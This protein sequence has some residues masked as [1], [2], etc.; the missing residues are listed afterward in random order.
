[1]DDIKNNEANEIAQENELKEQKEQ[2]LRVIADYENEIKRI[3]KDANHAMESAVESIVIEIAQ[4]IIGLYAALKTNDQ[5]VQNGIKLTLRNINNTFAKYGVKEIE[6]KIGDEFDP[7]LH[8]V[9][10]TNP[11]NAPEHDG[12]IVEILQNGYKFHHRVITPAVVVTGSFN[13]Q[14]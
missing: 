5:N 14:N 4:H 3:K 11:C 9:I 2:F 13:S 12:K 8:H 6:P 1:M 7:H 10:S